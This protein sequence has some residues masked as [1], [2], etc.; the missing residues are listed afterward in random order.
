MQYYVWFSQIRSHILLF[1]HLPY[2]HTCELEFDIF[3]LRWDMI[4]Q[5][6]FP[7]GYPYKFYASPLTIASILFFNLIMD[8][9]QFRIA[10]LWLDCGCYVT[11]VSWTL[12]I[13]LTTLGLGC[14]YQANRKGTWYNWY[15]PC[16]LIAY[17]AMQADSPLWATNHQPTRG[18]LLD[19][20]YR[21]LCWIRSWVRM[22]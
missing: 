6:F 1:Y 16:S 10:L 5:K 19:F 22:Y 7:N 11:V 4:D 13:C 8:K 18:K 3:L 2:I 20:L 15:V 17:A 14:T 12:V 21:Q 9:A